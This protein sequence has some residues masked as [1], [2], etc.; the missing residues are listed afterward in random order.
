M[1]P[2]RWALLALL[3]TVFVTGC[4]GPTKTRLVVASAHG[5]DLLAE[6]ERTFESAHPDV[7]VVGLYLGSNEIL[8]RLRAGKANPSIHV[9]WGADAVTLD[10]AAAENLLAPYRPTWATPEHP[11]GPGDLWW[12]V[13]ELP[14]VIGFNPKLA[15]KETCPKTFAELGDPKFAGRL[16][17]RDPAASGSMRTWLGTL[18]AS[19]PSED[20]GFALLRAIDAN[21]RSWEGSPEILFER[22]ESGPAAFTVWNL[23]DLVFQKRTKGYTFVAS[24]LSCDVPVVL[25]GVALVAGSGERKDAAAFFEHVTSLEALEQAARSHARIPVRSDFPKSKLDPDVAAV[26]F[27]RASVGRDVLA[28]SIR[29]WLRRF[30]DEVRGRSKK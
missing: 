3:T 14:M 12:G 4:G 16:V 20:D 2:L 29:K 11:R 5:V 26:A 21:T 18:V 10:T 1:S 24:G 6:A 27:T 19:A 23:T 7:D 28:G 8:E 25:D 17:L 15:T 9:V 22:L 13:Y 30:E